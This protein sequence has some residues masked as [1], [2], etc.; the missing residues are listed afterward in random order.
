MIIIVMNK[1]WK[2][3]T[4]LQ[5]IAFI[6]M[7]AAINGAFSVI[8]SFIFGSAIVAA[9]VLPCVNALAIYVLKPKWIAVYCITVIAIPLIVTCYDLTTT[10][11]Y[12]IPAITAGLLY[13]ALNKFRC[14]VAL[15]ILVCSLWTL[16]TTYLSFYLIGIIYEIDMISGFLTAI[17]KG[18]SSFATALFPSLMFGVSWASI[19]I[20]HLVMYFIHEKLGFETREYSFEKYLYPVLVIVFSD[21]SLVLA[22]HSTTLTYLFFSLS[23]FFTI[24]TVPQLLRKLRFYYYIILVVLLVAAFLSFAIF[25]KQFQ[26]E[27]VIALGTLFLDAVALTSFISLISKKQSC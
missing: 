6:A 21:L 5:N 27:T 3:E 13:G 10:L 22:F 25:A 1:T 4:P 11:F 15:T 9:L 24:F 26:T 20:N 17:G 16:G 14:P 7:M 12:I 23:L 18:G 19:S 8:I 2:R